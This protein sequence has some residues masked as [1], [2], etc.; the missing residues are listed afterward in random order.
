MKVSNETK[1]GALTA[2]AITLLIL[3]FNFLKGRSFLKTGNFLYAQYTDTKGLMVSNPVFVNGYQVGSV[4]DIE[5]VDENLQGIIVAIK[6]KKEYNIPKNSVAYIAENPLGTPSIA[7][8]LGDQ[9]VFLKTGDTIQTSKSGGILAGLTDKLG[10]VADQIKNT[11]ASL[12][13]VLKNIN[14]TLDPNTKNNLQ[15]V[16]A[17]LNK[18]T[19]GLVASAASLQQLL[20]TQSGAL[21]QSLNN[22]SDFTTNLKNNND[23]ITSTLKNI[24]TTTENLSKADI[25]GTINQLKTTVESLNTAV[26][27]LDSKEGSLGLLLN[28]K[29]L[30]NNLTNTTR[31][32]NILMDDLKTNPKRYV[33]FSVFGRKDKGTPLQAPLVDTAQKK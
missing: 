8:T 29:Q 31:S 3:G 27:K 25:D 19:T 9:K 33:S 20:N 6:L 2:I 28:D 23:K 14:S 24:E 17:N 7:I 26:L 13:V 11:V 10:P 4:F 1:V 21:A 30:Y 12:D 5:E 32:L 16:I 15:A 18:A 22:V